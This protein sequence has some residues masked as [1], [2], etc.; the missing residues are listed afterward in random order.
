MIE[1][2][3]MRTKRKAYHMWYIC[4]LLIVLFIHDMEMEKNNRFIK[5]ILYSKYDVL[6]CSSNRNS[7]INTPPESESQ[8]FLIKKSISAFFQIKKEFA[9][10][11]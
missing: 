8:Y 2:L 3:R 4:I 11:K 7:R 1:K 9:F 10:Y 5:E 6:F